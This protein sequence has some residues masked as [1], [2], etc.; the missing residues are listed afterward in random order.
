MCSHS[1]TVILSSGPFSLSFATDTLGV[2]QAY[3]GEKRDLESKNVFD[4]LRCIYNSAHPPV[5]AA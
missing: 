4:S 3:E 5:R 1:K 2:W